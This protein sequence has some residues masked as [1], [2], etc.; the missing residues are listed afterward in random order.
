MEVKPV[1]SK[2]GIQN[3]SV[4]GMAL[5]ALSLDLLKDVSPPYPVVTFSVYDVFHYLR[6]VGP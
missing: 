5:R 6:T 2:S 3:A 4:L 1:T